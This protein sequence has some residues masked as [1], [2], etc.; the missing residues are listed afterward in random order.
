MKRSI[1]KV[2]RETIVAYLNLCSKSCGPPFIVGCLVAGKK[3]LEP[4]PD[5]RLRRLKPTA[6]S[7]HIFV[8]S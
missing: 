6:R 2:Y 8:L 4:G 1:E 7:L 5:G 3:V